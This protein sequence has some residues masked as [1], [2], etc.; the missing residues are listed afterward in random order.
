MTTPRHQVP[1]LLIIV[2]GPPASGKSTLAEQIA[3]EMRLPFLSKDALKEELYDSLKTIEHMDSHDLGETAMRLMYTVAER[4]LEAGGGVVI[5]AN[6]F[7]GISEDDLAPLV[8]LARAV[9][10]HCDAPKETIK[11]RYVERAESG[12]RHPVHDDT[13]RVDDLEEKL[14]EGTFEPLELDVP[15]I[16]VDTTEDFVPSV[17]EIV[18]RLEE[19]SPATPPA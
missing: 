14:E 10:I 19:G 18:S 1:P 12:D 4:I 7:R 6:F 3:A 9:V 5:E 11:E 16:H 13:N 15:T 2:N 17:A 8:R